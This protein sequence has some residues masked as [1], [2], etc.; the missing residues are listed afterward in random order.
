[1]TLGL[2]NAAV[3]RDDVEAQAL[4]RLHDLGT[5]PR[6]AFAASKQQRSLDWCAAIRSQ[7]ESHV[8]GVVLEHWFGDEAQA[9]LRAAAT[10]RTR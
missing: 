5:L 8:D 2:L 6:S 9:L 4:Q 7:L 1:M 3:A 10:P